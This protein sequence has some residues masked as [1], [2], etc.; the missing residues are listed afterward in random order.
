MWSVT[1]EP[2]GTTVW[3]TTLHPI[4]QYLLYIWAI[5]SFSFIGTKHSM[6]TEPTVE[7]PC[8]VCKAEVIDGQEAIQ[9]D[10]CS[11][12]QHIACNSGITRDFYEKLNRGL[13]KLLEWFC[14]ICTQRRNG[15]SKNTTPVSLLNP[16]FGGPG[17][18]PLFV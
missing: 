18:P 4:L 6:A 8:I 12:W 13:D 3:F 11:L 17:L 16:H 5:Y 2:L 7:H 15:P 10:G 1:E 9:C 14:N